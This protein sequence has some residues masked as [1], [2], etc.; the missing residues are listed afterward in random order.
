[1]NAPV[2]LVTHSVDEEARQQAIQF[3]EEALA[4]ARAGRIV[5][6]VL[7]YER[8][9]GSWHWD[10]TTQRSLPNAVGQLEIIKSELVATYCTDAASA[11]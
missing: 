6:V 8:S 2:K 9:D 7:I 3:L 5:S 10:S 11:R 4:D 1:M